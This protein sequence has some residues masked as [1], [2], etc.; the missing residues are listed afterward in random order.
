MEAR[1][2]IYSLGGVRILRAGEPVAGLSTHK[3]EALLIYLASTRSPQPREVLADL[4]WDERTQSQAMGNLRGVL[5]NLRQVLGDTLTIT[6]DV[7]GINSEAE[8]W[9]DSFELEDSLAAIRRQG[10]LKADTARQAASVLELYKGEFLQGF[11]VFD[12]RGFEDWSVRERERIH[13]LAVDG[14]S[15]L[16]TFEIDEKEYQPGMAHAAR[17]L[18]LDP[19]M[20]SAHRQM[21]L[22]LAL[23]GQCSAA[24]R[25]YETCQKLLREDLS[26]EPDME[27]RDLH[28]YIRA[29]KLGAREEPGF[30]PLKT[31][32][33]RSHNLPVQLTSFIGREREMG[34]IKKLLASTH[35]L[36]LTGI[37]GTGKTR[38]AL[39]VSADLIAEFPG[40][41][42]LVEL[43][44][45][46]DPA[47]VEQ[48]VASVLAVRAVPER[49]LS[50]LLVE[51]V[52]EKHLLLI[53]DNCE[54]VV[55]VCA[56]LANLLL[57]NAPGIKIMATS[58]V[59]L[60][61]EGEVNYPVPPLAL[62][63]PKRTIPAL[64]LAQYEAVRLFIERATAMQP[65]FTVTNENATAVAQICTHLDGIP[66]ALELAAARIRL[67]SPDQ[68]SARLG[69][70]FNL[71]TGGNRATLPRQQTLRAAMDW[72]YD[73]LSEAEQILFRRLA[74]FAGSF[75]L[76]A[77]ETIC[78]DEIGRVLPT[79]GISTHQVLDLLCAMV[80]H[81]LASVQGRNGENCYFLLETVRE[82]A[83][84]KL[85]TS[86]ELPALQD[87]HLAYYL[88]F[89]MQGEFYTWIGES[90]WM[91]RFEIEYDNLRIAMERALATNL[92]SAILLEKSLMLFVG[93]TNRYREAYNWSLRILNLTENWPTSKMRAMALWIAGDR[94]A[95]L[96]E[97]Q[98]GQALV[99]T[100]LEM[101]RKLGDKIQ[102]RYSLLSLAY[103]NWQQR[104]WKQE[105]NYAEQ[106]LAIAEELG[107]K[108]GIQ[109]ALYELG[110]S[111]SLSGDNQTG[112]MYLEQSLEI[113]RQE[114]I[115]NGI[116]MVLQSLA[117][118]ARLEGDNTKAIALYTE[119]AQIKK[120]MGHRAAFADIL[121]HMGTIALHEGDAIKAR[122][123]FDESGV[124]FNELP[125]VLGQ[126][127]YIVGIAG[128]TSLIGQVECA[129]RLFGTAEALEERFNIEM[130]ASCHQVFDPLIAAVRERL[131]EGNFNS[132][133]A[134]GRKLTLE[135]AL[136][137]ARQ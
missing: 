28:N 47:Q 63:D 86:G 106:A 9:L 125:S 41:V 82:Y 133:W 96:R 55:E 66:L 24:L 126:Y 102:M 134:E 22:L 93:R 99:E 17:L 59:H 70:R 120:Q 112:C 100:S 27:T 11:S 35:L 128:V 118:L 62:P 75:S 60:N 18:D 38:L 131:G 79:S 115:P 84:E 119:S 127:E 74:V 121:Y 87:Q 56:Q 83:F 88:K 8:V 122:A 113:A 16:V 123:Q 23:S 45:L 20:E 76:E 5:T 26:V 64:A 107:D 6:R 132:A 37:G 3:A 48:T 136:E 108:F 25:Q 29:G 19:L 44:P 68:I 49:S 52:R 71:L 7:A 39:Q 2:E 117:R 50:D 31:T 130:C 40:G 105:Q 135:Q 95:I 14:L 104:N 77:V 53:L 94:F 78:A 42:W 54:H 101:A 98:Q 129:A 13:H 73:L 80:D 111:I 43:A 4:L 30:I 21:M 92:E 46:R 85:Q 34:E 12:C 116:A 10:K 69:D 36:T 89:A 103:M 15:E 81:S 72:S 110:E 67:L 109:D 61:L 97:Y 1:L 124:I 32:D 114:N 33:T 58:R 91:G 90:A 51:D 137:L 65:S 57:R